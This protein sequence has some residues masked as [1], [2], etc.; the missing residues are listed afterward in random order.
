MATD[1]A[2]ELLKGLHEVAREQAVVAFGAVGVARAANLLASVAR[3]SGAEQAHP[4]LDRV[5]VLAVLGGCKRRQREFQV[6]RFW[7]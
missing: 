7:K 6:L 1:L 5:V 3:P 4:A 2:S